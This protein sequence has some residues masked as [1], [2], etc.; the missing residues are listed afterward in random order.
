MEAV[1]I[2]LLELLFLLLFYLV[3]SSPVLE[4]DVAV[5]ENAMKLPSD[6]QINSQQDGHPSLILDKPW[7][8]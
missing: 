2:M 4:L 7:E 5:A 8:F 6:L 1:E 3:S